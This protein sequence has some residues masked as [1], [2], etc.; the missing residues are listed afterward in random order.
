MFFMLDNS[1]TEDYLKAIEERAIK[2]FLPKVKKQF[3]EIIKL[4]ILDEDIKYFTLKGLNRAHDGFYY[5]YCSSSKKNHT[6]ENNEVFGLYMHNLK[7]LGTTMA[8]CRLEGLNNYETSV[9]AS[10][11]VFHDI[12]RNL[13][14][15]AWANK[16]NLAHPLTGCEFVKKIPLRGVFYEN[17]KK[18]NYN[19]KSETRKEISEIVLVHFGRFTEGI[20]EHFKDEMP[21]LF[22]EPNSIQDLLERIENP[23]KIERIVQY[24]DKVG[25]L[26]FASYVPGIKEI[27]FTEFEQNEPELFKQIKRLDY[28]LKIEPKELVHKFKH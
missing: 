24:A 3:A 14:G 4:S 16:L 18:I 19:I 28:L 9:A 11:A 20:I 2:N 13:Y 22:E 21:S 1:Y 23:S 17:N 25:S 10:G 8:F 5:G 12:T 27:H 7:V 15:N 6:I 26:K